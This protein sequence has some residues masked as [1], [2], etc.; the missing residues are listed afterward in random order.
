MRR[1]GLAWWQPP[2][3]GFAPESLYDADYFAG[4]YAAR[5]YDDYA[6]QEAALRHSFARRLA[7]LGPPRPARACSTSARPSASA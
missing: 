4:A 2:A 6:G 5:G 1:C 3:T 7:R